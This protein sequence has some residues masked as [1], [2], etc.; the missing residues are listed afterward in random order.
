MII[1]L[2][3]ME[4]DS[5]S[6]SFWFRKLSLEVKKCTYIMRRYSMRTKYYTDVVISISAMPIM[7]YNLDIV[8]LIARECIKC[9]REVME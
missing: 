2:R 1:S 7:A 6:E 9:I 5:T 8:V 4:G 3:I